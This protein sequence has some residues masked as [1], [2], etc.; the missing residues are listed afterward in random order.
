MPSRKRNLLNL[1]S[2]T[3]IG[4]RRHDLRFPG[5]MWGLHLLLIWQN[6]CCETPKYLRTRVTAVANG[7]VYGF[8]KQCW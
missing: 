1:L 8:Q 5:Q 2:L 4:V 7:D 6:V 3:A